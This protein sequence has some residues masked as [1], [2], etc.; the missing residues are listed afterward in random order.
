LV[1]TVVVVANF[2][3]LTQPACALFQITDSGLSTLANVAPQLTAL[4][5]SHVYRVTNAGVATVARMTRLESL[6]VTRQALQ[7]AMF[8]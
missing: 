2:T 4:N 5:I 3:F 6:A 8:A 7:V 1:T